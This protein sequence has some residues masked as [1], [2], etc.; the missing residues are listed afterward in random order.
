MHFQYCNFRLEQAKR[1]TC[2]SRKRFVK[3]YK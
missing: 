3:E 1:W 2:I